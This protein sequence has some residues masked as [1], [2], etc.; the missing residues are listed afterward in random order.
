VSEGISRV[1][2]AARPR[3]TPR[4]DGQYGS[5]RRIRPLAVQARAAEQNVKDTTAKGRADLEAKVTEARKSADEHADRLSAK[6]T[7]VSDVGQHRWNDVQR[8]WKDHVAQFHER[9]EEKKAERDVNRA[10]RRAERAEEDALDAVD[11]A[12][13]VLEEAEYAVLDAALARTEADEVAA[14]A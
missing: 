12:A 4:E 10:E 2:D 1:L 5:F 6:A 14:S 3:S 8:S 11:F 7:E 9:I 13:A